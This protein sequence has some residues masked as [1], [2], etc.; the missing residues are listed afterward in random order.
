MER[1]CA[2]HLHAFTYVHINWR[3]GGILSVIAIVIGNEHNDLR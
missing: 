2:M 1:I 3:I